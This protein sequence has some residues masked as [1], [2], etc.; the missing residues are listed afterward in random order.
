MAENLG[1]PDTWV[2]SKTTPMK[3]QTM[4]ASEMIEKAARL[5]RD[6]DLLYMSL[7]APSMAEKAMREDARAL[8][9]A[10]K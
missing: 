9:E 4:T 5:E 1:S 6:A 3:E 2:M 8:R 10:A 7:L